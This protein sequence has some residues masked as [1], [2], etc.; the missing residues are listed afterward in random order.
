MTMPMSTRQAMNKNSTVRDKKNAGFVT[1][2]ADLA[3]LARMVAEIA[4]DD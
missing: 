2:T 1:V 4:D 3:A